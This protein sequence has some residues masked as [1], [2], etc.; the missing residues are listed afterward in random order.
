MCCSGGT[1]SY[2]DHQ[3]ARPGQPEHIEYALYTHVSPAAWKNQ[4][5]LVVTVVGGWRARGTWSSPE[6]QAAPLAPS[7]SASFAVRMICQSRL[8]GGRR[9]STAW[10]RCTTQFPFQ[11]RSPDMVP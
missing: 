2:G 8:G 3:R 6:T 5:F 1:T 11:S 7:H 4:R 10:R 9:M